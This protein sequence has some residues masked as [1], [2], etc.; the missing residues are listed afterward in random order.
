MRQ[1]RTV[2]QFHALGNETR[3]QVFGKLMKVAPDGLAA[4]EIAR[5]LDVAPNT[6]SGHL[7]VLTRAGLA[8]YR[9]QGRSL[10]YSVELDTVSAFL[11]DFVETWCNGHRE[12][13]ERIVRDN[14]A[15]DSARSKV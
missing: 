3:L 2:D 5:D 12:L 15:S 9:R 10:I 14:G 4:G 1:D 8:S 7:A 13:A 11:V 6:L